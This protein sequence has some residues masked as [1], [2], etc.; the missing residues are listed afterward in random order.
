MIE[1]DHSQDLTLSLTEISFS[2]LHLIHENLFEQLPG[3]GGLEELGR[4][5]D[6]E[7][8]LHINIYIF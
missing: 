7:D 3:V 8:P 1:I 5:S 4:G 2:R 6:I